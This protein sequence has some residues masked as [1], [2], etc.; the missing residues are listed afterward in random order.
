ML[1]LV[2]S[3]V[4]LFS[5]QAG[6]MSLHPCTPTVEAQATRISCKEGSVYYTVI[7]KTLMSRNIEICQGKNHVEYKTAYV[8]KSNGE[9]KILGRT[10]IYDGDFTYVLRIGGASFKSTKPRLKLNHCVTPMHGA[11][12]IGN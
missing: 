5:L 3:F 11:F 10:T 7:I 2:A 8:E 6:A 12:S 1:K 9:G 4:L